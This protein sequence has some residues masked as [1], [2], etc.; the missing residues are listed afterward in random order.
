MGHN[1]RVGAWLR[2]MDR[3]ARSRVFITSNALLLAALVMA[4]GARIVPS[5]QATLAQ[6]QLSTQSAITITGPGVNSGSA[7]AASATI[8]AYVL[9]DVAQPGVYTLAEGARVQNLVA[10][11]GGALAD[12]DLK[13]VNLAA[14]VVDGQEI[15]VPRVG[16]TIPFTLG[17]KV[18]INVASAGDFHSALHLELATSNRIVAYRVAHGAFTAVSQLLLVPISRATYDKIKDLV[19]V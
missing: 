7:G 15:Y 5:I 2:W 9:G 18:D 14:P 10:A 6:T 16:E 12:A 3:L 4:I 17:G 13:R 11:A 19:T 8:T 1:D